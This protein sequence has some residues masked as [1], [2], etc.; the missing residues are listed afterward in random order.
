M[1]EDTYD[2]GVDSMFVVLERLAQGSDGPRCS[3][4]SAGKSGKLLPTTYRS[5]LLERLAAMC[6]DAIDNNFGGVPET[7]PRRDV[8]LSLK[9]C[10]CLPITV[11]FLA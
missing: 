1:S 7:E 3:S 5:R 11:L 9:S 4:C 6:E 8:S 10:A 2:F